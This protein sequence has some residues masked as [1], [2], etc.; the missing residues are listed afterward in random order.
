MSATCGSTM[1]VP[2]AAVVCACADAAASAANATTRLQIDRNVFDGLRSV[3]GYRPPH[4]R[5]PASR[6]QRFAVGC[7]GSAP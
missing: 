1:T 6:D 3:I 5:A 7:A 2:D 4:A